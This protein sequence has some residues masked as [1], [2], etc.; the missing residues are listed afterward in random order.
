MGL[1]IVISDHCVAYEG[2]LDAEKEA[3]DSPYITGEIPL[4]STEYNELIKDLKIP[5][6]FPKGMSG[7]DGET[8]TVSIV[9]GNSKVTFTWWVHCPEGWESLNI[10]LHKVIDFIRQKHP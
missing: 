7:L 4:S 8:Y 1:R 10:F 2:N 6:T 3:R 9:D 5:T